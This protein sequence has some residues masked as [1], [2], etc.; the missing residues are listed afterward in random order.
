MARPMKKGLDYF[1]FDVD[2][3]SDRKI[4][5]LKA[6]YG[7]DG[8]A[9]YVYLI[10]ELYR[11][12]YCIKYNDDLILDISDELNISENS[13][14]Q[15]IDFLLSRSLF[16][17]KLAKSD[18]VLTAESVQRR[19]QEAK[20]GSKR[21][22]EVEARY[23]LLKAED[24]YSFIKVCLND[25]FSENN[26]SKSEKNHSFSENNTTK[27][28]KENKSKS[29]YM[30]GEKEPDGFARTPEPD[31]QV[32]GEH[33][34]VFLTDEELEKLKNKIS[35]YQEYI[36]TLSRYIASKGDPYKSHFA[37]IL[38]WYNRDLKEGKIKKKSEHSFDLDEFEEFTLHNVPNIVRGDKHE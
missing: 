35:D 30:K 6:R 37:T 26:H 23:W 29:K 10:C 8:I 28:S 7:T 27:E 4:K 16:D 9:V 21:E 11:S 32:Y 3:F 13:T 17:D 18:K 14:R 34:N 12:G 38:N 1:P 20:K 22:I 19:Y 25:G 31:K 5:R 15:I 36:E 2:F 33:K 24:T